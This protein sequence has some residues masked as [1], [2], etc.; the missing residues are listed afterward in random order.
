[1]RRAFPRPLSLALASLSEQLT[2]ATAL[3]SV[4][5]VWSEAVGESIAAEA[6]PVSEHFGVVTIG[7]RS[8]VWAHELEL[9]GPEL[10]ERLND[11]MG[12]PLV[13]SLRCRAT[14]AG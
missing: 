5:R 9:M 8:S 14:G 4:Q 1:M 3:A 6:R 13:R 7:C 2:P 10:V 11:A 12:T